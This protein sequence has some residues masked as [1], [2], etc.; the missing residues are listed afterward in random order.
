MPGAHGVNDHRYLLSMAA[1]LFD[2]VDFKASAGQCWDETFW[3][4]GP[5][6]CSTF[7]AISGPP[8]PPVSKAFSDGGV[9]VLRAAAPATHVIVDCAEVGMNG[10]GGHGHNDI[11]SFELFMA[12]CNLVT[13]CG[14]YLY[15][16]S[17]EWRNRFRS[18]AFHNGVQVD[19]EE[20]NR[21]VAPD[22]LW[23]LRY[24]AVPVDA[25]LTCGADADTFRGGHRGYE[26]LASPVS[27]AREIV[28]HKTSARVVV[29]DRLD[30]TG[31][32]TLTWRFHLDPAVTADVH[33]RD[34]RIAC[35]SRE[36][37][38]RS[39]LPRAFT[40]SLEPGWVSPSYGVKLPAAV[41]VWTGTATLPLSA[42]HSFS[43]ERVD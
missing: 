29:R 13:D 34:V 5:G 26:R 2:R 12:G 21:F 6:A 22:A 28:V 9:Y 40:L 4:L 24:D 36:F 31:R 42:S 32:H 8:T 15:T 11:L 7:D 41:V 16:T 23:Q 43:T 25:G 33:G 35:G 1:V 10:R 20:V 38:L 27:H 37:W 19:E 18:T 3:L 39:D 30:G 17:H 14:A